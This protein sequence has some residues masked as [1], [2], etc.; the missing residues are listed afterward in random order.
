MALADHGRGHGRV[1]R[2][3]PRTPPPADDGGVYLGIKNLTE[4]GHL[5][6]TDIRHINPSDIP[7]WTKR[8]TPRGGDIVFTY[9]ATLHR[10]AIIPEGFYGTLGR[11]LALMRVDENVVDRRFLLYSFLSPQW[12]RLIEQRLNVGS[13]V[14]RIPLTEF[15][16]YPV[17]IPDLNVQR[18][19]ASTLAAFDDLIEN[20]RRR[21]EILEEMARL[22]Y[23]EWF[24]QYRFPG[25]SENEF[26]DTDLGQTPV[27][28]NIQ[29]LGDVLTLNYGKGLKAADRR[30][31]EVA[32]YG[33]G[34]LVGWHD[35]ALVGGPAIVVG[36]K[37]NVGSIFWSEQDAYPID[38]TYFVETSLPLRWSHQMLMTLTFIDSHAAVPGLSRDQAYSIL[39][40]VPPSDL[41]DRY[42]ETVK[43]LYDL[44]RC[45]AAQNA[46]LAEARDLLLPRLVSGELDVSELEFELE[47]V[48]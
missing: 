9:E 48:S 8:V 10:Y 37:G 4:D 13:T 19:I 43:P 23:R 16:S 34:G 1:L 24:V 32:V 33:S 36:R 5:D 20:N 7:K 40:A 44:A 45:L 29:K 38:T 42:E 2:R 35:E 3:P 6:L 41:A 22:L 18:Q 15:P 26:V 12:R 21:I 27:G 30:G 31:G 46:V 39:V 14:D 11:R 47:P 28:W 25:R 17:D